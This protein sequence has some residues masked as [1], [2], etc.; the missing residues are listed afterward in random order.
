MKHPKATIILVLTLSIIAYTAGLYAGYKGGE[1]MA[2]ELTYKTY[3][4]G[5]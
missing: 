1:N 3:D 2:K 4:S 5:Q